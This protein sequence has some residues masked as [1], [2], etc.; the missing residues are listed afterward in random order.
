MVEEEKTSAGGDAIDSEIENAKPEV[1]VKRKRGRPRLSESGLKPKTP[2]RDPN[3]PKRGR[4]RP[5]IYPPGMRPSQ[6]RSESTGRP[7]GRPRKV[8]APDVA[9][10]STPRSPLKVALKSVSAKLTKSDNG[11]GSDNE[12]KG[13]RGRPPKKDKTSEPTAAGEAKPKGKRGR[14]PKAAAAPTPMDTSEKSS[15]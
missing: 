7:R 6:V 15:D 1:P 2:P 11:S 4:G 5:R 3:A 12:K 13:R 10:D 9:S 8:P 14:P